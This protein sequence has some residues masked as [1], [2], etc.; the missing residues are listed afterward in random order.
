MTAKTQI[1]DVMRR[2]VLE[3]FN[4]TDDSARRRLIEQLY[5]PD[6]GFHDAEGSV[7]GHDAIDAKVRSLQQDAPGLSFSV[8]VEPAVVEDLGR[9][10]WALA[11]EGA[12]PVVSGMDVGLV[13]DGRLTALYTFVDPR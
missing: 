13:R 10:S 4:T 1:A 12:S 2:N 5:Q 6:A 3:V 7:T 11:P 9:I 8:T